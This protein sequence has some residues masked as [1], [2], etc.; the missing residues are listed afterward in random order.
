MFEPLPGSVYWLHAQGRPVCARIRIFCFS[1]AEKLSDFSSVSVSAW[2]MC[3]ES[4]WLQLVLL[5]W[6]NYGPRFCCFSVGTSTGAFTDPSLFSLNKEV[7]SILSRKATSSSHIEADPSTDP[8]M[9][10]RVDTSSC[11]LFFFFVLPGW[12]VIHAATLQ[13]IPSVLQDND[14]TEMGLEN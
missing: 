10:F 14:L 13:L 2:T 4:F 1:N 9:A 12:S 8:T 11:K 5:N 3:M 6:S 7:T